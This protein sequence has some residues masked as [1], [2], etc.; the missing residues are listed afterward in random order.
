MS[1]WLTKQPMAAAMTSTMAKRGSD[2]P[3]SVVDS[4]FANDDVAKSEGCSGCF[5]GFRS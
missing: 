2:G 3:S 1:S 4:A 5:D